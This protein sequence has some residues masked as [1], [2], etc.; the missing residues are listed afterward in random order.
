MRSRVTGGDEFLEV[1]GRI[2]GF[3]RFR[4]EFALVAS[5]YTP[6]DVRS[7][8][9][10]KNPE[11]RRRTPRE[12]FAGDFVDGAHVNNSNQAEDLSAQRHAVHQA[13]IRRG[14]DVP[15]FSSSF[16]S[17]PWAEESWAEEHDHTIRG[18]NG[19]FHRRHKPHV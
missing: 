4:L 10:A 17:W 3:Q 18:A 11:R 1:A 8:L 19:A 15:Q 13:K 12:A 9:R 14:H 5:K 6:R 16:R 2:R 7:A